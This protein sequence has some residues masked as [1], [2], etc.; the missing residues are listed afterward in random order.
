MNDEGE[1]SDGFQERNRGLRCSNVCNYAAER[2]RNLG[3]KNSTGNRRKSL[4]WLERPLVPI[5]LSVAQV[6]MIDFRGLLASN[7]GQ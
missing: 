4:K 3:H 5:F 1:S 6:Q 7:R 2:A